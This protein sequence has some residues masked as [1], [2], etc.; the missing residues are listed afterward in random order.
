MRRK[1]MTCCG[2]GQR[3]A[4]TCHGNC[5]RGARTWDKEVYTRCC[6]QVHLPHQMPLQAP[7]ESCKARCCA[8]ACSSCWGQ[9]GCGVCTCGEEAPPIL[10]PA[11]AAA[12]MPFLLDKPIHPHSILVKIVGMTVSFQGRLCKE[13][14]I[15]GIVLKV[16]MVVRL[17]KM[18]LMVRGKEEMAITAIWVINGVDCCCIGFHNAT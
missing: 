11:P 7:E 16:D 15:C 17:R 10:P 12:S 4:C 9:R 14:T 8:C 3:R 5:D 18:Q 13:H 2:G 6:H 1:R